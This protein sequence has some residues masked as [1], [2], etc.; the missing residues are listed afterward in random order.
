MD[1]INCADDFQPDFGNLWVPVLPREVLSTYSQQEMAEYYALR[2]RLTVNAEDNPVGAGWILPSWRTVMDNWKKYRIHII[3]GGRRSSKSEFASRLCVW[4]AG[5][6][7]E[8]KV[9]AYHVNEGR[10]IEDQ[11]EFVWKALPRSL[12]NITPKK[13][14]FHSL[15][16]SQKNGFTDSVAII[17]PDP[18]AQRGGTIYFGNYRQYAQDQQVTEGFKAHLIWGDEEMPLEMFK[19]LLMT[20]TDYRGRIVLTFTTM[21]GWTPLVQALLAKTR[22]LQKI[23]SPF[24]NRDVPVLQESLSCPGGPA[25]VHYFQSVDNPF[26]DQE[27]FRKSMEGRP[28]SE[29]LALAHGIPTKS[30]EGVFPAF[31]KEINVIPHE[32]LPWLKPKKDKNGAPIHY[33]VTRY[34]AVDPAGSKNWFIL[35]VAIDGAGTWWIYR[36]WPDYDDWALPG[37]TPEGKPG[38]ASKGSKRGIKDY[39]ELIRHLEGD[40]EIFERFIDPRLGAAEKQSQDGATTIISDLD[41]AGMTFIPAP[42]VEIENGLQLINNLLAWDES[43]P[44]DSLNSPRLFISERCQNVIYALSEYTNFNRSEACKDPIDCLR[45]LCVSN[46]DFLEKAKDYTEPSTFSY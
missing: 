14:M 6:I 13:G 44:R 26:I 17:P 27:S 4:A 11:Q 21:Q 20:L 8:A 33:P 19:T 1:K 41:D 31:S 28:V 34:M 25:L 42:G 40:E 43:K 10:S 35:W 45:Y 2:T 15:Q 32:E 7:P 24:L 16:Y 18:G 38:P 30:M 5:T 37:P 29:V 22:T 3:L 12:K 46:C 39:V 9:R 36:E 23:R